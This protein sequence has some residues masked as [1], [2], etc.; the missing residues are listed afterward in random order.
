MK[1]AA[2][3]RSWIRA[4]C[5][6]LQGLKDSL[7]MSLLQKRNLNVTRMLGTEKEAEAVE[8]AE[9]GGEAGEAEK[10]SRR[11]V[12]S[13]ETSMKY[14]DSEALGYRGKPVW[15][16]YRRN[17][18]GRKPPPTRRTCIRKGQLSTAS[19]CPICRDE[20]LVL[21]FQNVK[22]LEQFVSPYTG[23]VLDSMLTGVCQ[24]QHQQLIIE[25]MQAWDEGLLEK[26]LPTR[27]Y[28]YKDYK[29]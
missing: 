14:L 13:P 5:Q 1:M 17:F 2:P 29:S 12:V 21:N 23:E 26:K 19:P 4:G 20:Y 11:K 27:V 16:Y 28:D 8:E 7:S 22:L 10:D 9:T 24:K 15:F 18:K 25:V 3:L 6:T